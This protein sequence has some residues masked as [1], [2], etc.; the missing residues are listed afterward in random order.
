[1]AAMKWKALKKYYKQIN[2]SFYYTGVA[3]KF[4]GT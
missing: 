1:M 2:K 4:V 3:Q